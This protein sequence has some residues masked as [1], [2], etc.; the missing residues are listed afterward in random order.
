MIVDWTV[1]RIAYIS[2]YMDGVD[3]GQDMSLTV[4]PGALEQYSPYR[5]IVEV[6][7]EYRQNRTRGSWLSFMTG[8]EAYHTGQHLVLDLGA[9]G[10]D[11]WKGRNWNNLSTANPEWLAVYGND[12][13]VGDFGSTYGLQ[14][15][16]PVSLTWTQIASANPDNTGNTMVAWNNGLVVDFGAYGAHYWDGT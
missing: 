9:S 2:D 4:P 7:D 3:A 12:V 10:V 6:Y 5:W 16:D 13:L 14:Q 8:E 15:Y 1:R 11:R